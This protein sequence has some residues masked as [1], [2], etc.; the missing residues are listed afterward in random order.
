[1]WQTARTC[2]NYL[3]RS[4]GSGNNTWTCSARLA[5]A[6]RKRSKTHSPR[7]P[8]RRLGGAEGAPVG[9]GVCFRFPWP[10]ACCQSAQVGAHANYFSLRGYANYSLQPDDNDVVADVAQ[11]SAPQPTKTR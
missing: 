2:Y 10:A 6:R 9:F 5:K 7:R 1:M 8:L 4:G 3:F 11:M